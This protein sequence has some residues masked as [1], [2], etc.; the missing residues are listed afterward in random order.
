M[1]NPPA[2]TDLPPLRL[3]ATAALSR[4][5]IAC[6]LGPPTRWQRIPSYTLV[7]LELPGYAPPNLM[8]DDEAARQAACGLG[9]PVEIVSSPWTHAPSPAHAIDRHRWVGAAL[10]P[11]LE[12]SRKQ[13][14]ESSGGVTLRS[15]TIRVYRAQPSEPARPRDDPEIACGLLWPTPAQMRALVRG[16]SLPDLRALAERDPDL[17]AWERLPDDALIYLPAGYGERYLLRV[18]AKYGNQALFG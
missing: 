14:S 15:V 1:D 7:P 4:G 18:L 6:M 2:E 16:V 17:I 11:F 13:P 5:R 12:L 8:P 10:A 9:Q 3:I